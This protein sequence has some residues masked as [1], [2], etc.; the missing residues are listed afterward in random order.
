[1]QLV[2]RTEMIEQLLK[3]SP[4]IYFLGLEIINIDL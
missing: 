4:F 2:N 3:E 1:M